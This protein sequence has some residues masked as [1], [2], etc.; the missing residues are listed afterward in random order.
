VAHRSRNADEILAR[1]GRRSGVLTRA[2]LLAAGLSHDQVAHRVRTGLLAV[3]FP[4]VYRLGPP[5]TEA[6][7]LAAVRACGDGAALSG[8]PAAWW[9]G[10]IRGRPPAPEVSA[11]RERKLSGLRTRRRRLHP[12]EVATHRGIPVT[13]APLT[14]VDLASPLAPGDLARA[15]HEAGVKYGTTPRQVA[16]ALARR[17]NAKGAAKLRAVLEG[18]EADRRREREAYAR[19]DE[20]RRY[21]WGDVVEDR[22]ALLRELTAL[23]ASAP[24]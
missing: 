1:L 9:L 17:P 12:G 24:A 22:R 11:P 8:R 14:L 7:Y 5:R 19:G 3:E 4:G 20:F 6:R 21:T 13:S 2:Q 15:C 16:E 10:L 23:L 18:W